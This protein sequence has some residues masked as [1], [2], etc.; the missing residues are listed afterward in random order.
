MGA[1]FLYSYASKRTRHYFSRRRT[2]VLH[3]IFELDLRNGTEDRIRSSYG[4]S[5][6]MDDLL[7]LA[8]ELRKH[9]GTILDFAGH[10]KVST[11]MLKAANEI[12]RLAPLDPDI[13]VI[14]GQD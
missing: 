7:T 5:A 10:K 2:I 4:Y 12:E 9:S 3:D 1:R 6:M 11:L 8:A 13:E 14:K